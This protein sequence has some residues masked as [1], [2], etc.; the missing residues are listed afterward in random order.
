M[1]VDL[2]KIETEKVYKDLSVRQVQIDD[3]VRRK[4]VKL[5]G[6]KPMLQCQLNGKL[7]EV[8]W[9]TGS[10]VTLVDRGWI[11][12][13]FPDAEVYSVSEF[14]D[15]KELK[16]K[17]ANSTQIRFDGVAILELVLGSEKEGVLV[18]VLIASDNMAEPILGYNVIEHLILNGTP[19]QRAGLRTSLKGKASGVELLEPLAALIQQRA[20]EP[21]FLTEVRTSKSITVPAGHKVRIRCRLKA[22]GNADEQSV[23]FSPRLMENDDDLNILETVSSLKRGHT[24]YVVVEV[25]NETKQDKT[26]PKGTTIGSIHSVAAVTPMT[27]MMSEMKES[28]EEISVNAVEEGVSEDKDDWVPNWDLSH[29]TE[30]QKKPVLEVLTEFKD[31]FSRDESD[32]GDI[33]D[34]EMD[35]NLQD[36]EPVKEAYRKIPRNLYAEVKNYINDLVQNGWI[37]ESFSSY[38]SPI[39][40]VRKKDGGLRMCVDYRKLNS[41]TTP[42]CQPI[43]RVQDIL[44]GLAGKRWFSTLDMSKAYHQGY[45]SEH[46]RHLTAFATPWT[47]YE[48]VRI[49]FGLRNAPP[50]F[51]RYIN[52]LL[53]DLKGKICDP[54]LDDILIHAVT[55]LEHVE[56]LRKVLQRLRSK[57]VKL[58]ADKC[59][60]M[61][62]EVRYLGRLISK[63]GY[64]ADPED[65]KALNK[66]RSAPK[67]VGELRSLLGF[68]GYFRCYVK[69]F[70]KKAKPLYNLLKGCG[71]NES[72]SSGK[73][74]GVKV[75]KRKGQRYDSRERVEWT[76]EC[77]EVVDRLIDHL[78]SSEVIAYPDW[79]LPFFLN[80]DASNLGLGAVLYQNQNGVDRVI[81]YASRTLSESEKNYNFHSGKLEFLA[82]YWAVTERF[83]DYLRYGP[84]FTVYTDN[85][86]LTYVLTSAKLNAVGLRWVAALADYN[87]TIRYKAGKENIDADNL[88]RK[89][90][91]ISELKNSCTETFESWGVGAVLAGSKRGTE[92]CVVSCNASLC[93][94]TAKTEENVIVSRRELKDAQRSDAVIGPVLEYVE[95]GTRP[96]RQI[97]KQLSRESKLLMRNFAKL[98]ITEDGVLIRKTA[99]YQQIVLP[100]QFHRLVY[101]ELHEKMAHIGSERVLDLAQ[102]RFYWPHMGRD[103][104]H[105]IRRKC[106]CVVKKKPNIAE[107][108]PLKPITASYPFEMISID[109]VHLDPCK[110]GFTYAL[111]VIDHF[112]RFCQIYATRT[113]SSK[114]AASKLFGE[115]ILQFGFP[116]QIHH[117]Q[118]P[119]F[120]SQ[121]FKE[122]HKLTKIRASNTTPYHPMGDGQVERCNRTIINMCKALEENEKGNWKSHLPKLAF[123]YNSTINKTTGFT[124]FYLM[125]GRESILPIDS[126]FA[127]EF[128]STSRNKS[129][130]EFV[131]DWQRSMKEAYE[132]ANKRI[133]KTAEYNKQYYDKNRKVREV[134]IGV[135]D[136]VLV[137]N[138]REKGGTGKLRS[139]WERNLFQVVEKRDD[140]P[141]Y[142]VKNVNKAKDVR[143]LHRNMLMKVEELPEEMFESE[144]KQA[145][146][147]A[148]KKQPM[149]KNVQTRRKDQ[150][151]SENSNV[152]D[153][154]KESEE[155]AENVE[156]WVYQERGPDFSEGGRDGAGVPETPENDS[157]ESVDSPDE[158]PEENLAVDVTDELDEQPDLETYEPNVSVEENSEAD[159][160]D[161]DAVVEEPEI[162]QDSDS[163]EEEQQP[164]RRSSRNVKKRQIFT[165]D[166][167]GGKPRLDNG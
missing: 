110:G 157:D 35:I 14:L 72:S 78:Q 71:S 119:E 46:C 41:K 134:E 24:N 149:D 47:L 133:V 115:F 138:M 52:R 116:R 88:S 162:E 1:I 87:F 18:P 148:R 58:R 109:F 23:Y 44:D 80:C 139:H 160:L 77:Q 123:A 131:E 67:N 146:A 95:S 6:D 159:E 114:A 56:S 4:L 57:G 68:L 19:E 155:E 43:P 161:E 132:L 42:D 128:A 86:P 156:V 81:S 85:N 99:K 36:K 12:E 121:L 100:Q 135:G 104:E 16:L 92:R 17:A 144:V 50:V 97:W 90:M 32:I 152:D 75:E 108:A 143:V 84:G 165:Y 74:K 65:T 122:L 127:E 13:N 37:R 111:V 136:K 101:S 118:G 55:F 66:F 8:L 20:N 49:P 48:W 106:R 112:T 2:E 166:E 53:G 31:V 30:E 76:K 98:K 27:K 38:S 163:S 103:I 153:V 83:S 113:K 29:L 21:D 151:K 94:L 26:L 73:E 5:I 22:Q 28:A 60:F 89:P 126:M 34:F 82:L 154:E 69:D 91:D 93:E 142:K 39:V 102:Q 51:Q 145:K 64:R 164:I 11:G 107:R 59:E 140:F 10:M 137:R 15:D 120:N 62:E 63:D 105:Y 70:A 96:Q 79:D 61:K 3:K 45:I 129:H 117:D 9:D 158:V 150:E 25:L 130:R 167:V 147:P 40:C 125:F 54:Y 124:P 7:M 33:P 141:V